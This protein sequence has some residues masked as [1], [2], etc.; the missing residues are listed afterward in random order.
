MGSSPN[1]GESRDHVT[2][3]TNEENK[4]LGPGKRKV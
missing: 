2:R 4:V 1:D 3:E